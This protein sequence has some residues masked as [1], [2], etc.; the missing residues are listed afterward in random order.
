M[1]NIITIPMLVNVPLNPIPIIEGIV[2]I[3]IPAK[4]DR[5]RETP[6]I[7]KNGWIFNFDI[8]NI[9]I[10]IQMI[11]AIINEIPCI[12]NSLYFNLIN[13]ISKKLL[14]YIIQTIQLLYKLLYNINNEN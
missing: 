10:I 9:I 12:F 1:P 3:G 14:N 6:I 2:F 4:N 11:K 8:A 5:S 7:D 13:S